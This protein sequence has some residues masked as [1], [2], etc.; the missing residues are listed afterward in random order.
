M[1][2]AEQLRLGWQR[3]ALQALYFGPNNLLEPEAAW[4]AVTQR[5]GT[6]VHQ[7]ELGLGGGSVSEVCRRRKPSA[8]RA[9]NTPSPITCALSFGAPLGLFAAATRA[10]R[11]C[12]FKSLPR[13]IVR[14][15]S[16]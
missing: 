16:A 9:K 2:P 10:Q 8:K 5:W 12:C 4:A 1:S 13:S 3:N 11:R 7:G 15:P 14:N 6:R